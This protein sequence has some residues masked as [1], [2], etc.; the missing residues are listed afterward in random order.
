M[1]K[2]PAFSVTVDRYVEYVDLFFFRGVEE[3]RPDADIFEGFYVIGFN[4]T[5]GCFFVMFQPQETEFD[6]CL[7]GVDREMPG[8]IGFNQ[9]LVDRFVA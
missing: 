4:I 1:Y 5:P 2:S 8:H 9:F 3:I 6:G 7:V